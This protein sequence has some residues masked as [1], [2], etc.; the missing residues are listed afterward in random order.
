MKTNEKL[1]DKKERF[2]LYDQ[3]ITF[4]LLILRLNPGFVF[5]KSRPFTIFWPFYFVGVDL[6]STHLRNVML[7]VFCQFCVSKSRSFRIFQPF[8]RSRLFR[9]WESCLHT[10]YILCLFFSS[11]Y[12]LN[13]RTV[14]YIGYLRNIWLFCWIRLTQFSERVFYLI[15]V[16]SLWI[17]CIFSTF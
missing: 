7:H 2:C 6:V 15:H 12:E 4:I 5:L 13:L 3:K 9:F 16:F 10:L 14:F 11:F 8:C 17:G 1:V